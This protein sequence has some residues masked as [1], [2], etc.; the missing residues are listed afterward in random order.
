MQILKEKEEKL[1]S[2]KEILAEVQFEKCTPK[3]EDL[4]KQL[5]DKLKAD[6]ELLVIEKVHQKFGERRANIS[7]YL[8]NDKESLKKA[9]VKNKKVKKKE[10]AKKE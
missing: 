9:E 2:R 4:K 3:K 5:S 8:Y 10:E 6:H 7:A 1:L